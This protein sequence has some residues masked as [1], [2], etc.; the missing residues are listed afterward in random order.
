[1]GSSSQMLGEFLF[2]GLLDHPFQSLLQYR[3]E[4]GPHLLLQRARLLL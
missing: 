3:S 1:M 2:Q 4:L